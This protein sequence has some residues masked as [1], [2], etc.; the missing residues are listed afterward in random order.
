MAIVNEYIVKEKLSNLF[1]KLLH[2]IQ[3]NSINIKDAIEIFDNK[4]EEIIK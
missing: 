4:L 2:Q 3:A 1:K